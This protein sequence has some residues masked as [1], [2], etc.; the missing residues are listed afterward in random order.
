MKQ[1][2]PQDTL[3]SEKVQSNRCKTGKEGGSEPENDSGS[4]VTAGE[5][6]AAEQGKDR[7]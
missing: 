6:R 7:N 5:H 1:E 4:R 3:N 2:Q